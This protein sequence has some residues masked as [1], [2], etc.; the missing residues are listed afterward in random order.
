MSKTS[1]TVAKL[2]ARPTGDQEIA[3]LTPG[4]LHS[5]VEIDQEIFSSVILSLP[6]IPEGQWSVSGENMYWLIA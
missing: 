3:D 2:D 4:R 6:R 1:A 5:F